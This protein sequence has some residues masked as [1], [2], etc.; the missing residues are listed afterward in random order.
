VTFPPAPQLSS[1]KEKADS[2][3]AEKT[4][5]TILFIDDE[6][7][8]VDLVRSA[9]QEEHTFYSAENGEAALATLKEFGSQI[10]LVLCDLMMPVMNG[11]ELYE[12]VRREFPE[13]AHRFVFVTGGAMSTA[14]QEFI[15]T[16]KQPVVFK[17]F[18]L[19]NLRSM[20]AKPF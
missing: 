13:M 15:D 11:M 12:R 16:V 10:D 20:I 7:A 4:H 9:L 17:P 18:S 2:T 6:R 3:A 1:K 14:A 5:K 19:K 8:I